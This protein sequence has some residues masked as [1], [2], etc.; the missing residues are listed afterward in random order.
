MDHIDVDNG[1][2]RRGIKSE[3]FS[4]SGNVPVSTGHRRTNIKVERWVKMS[5]GN[6]YAMRQCW[7]VIVDWGRRVAIYAD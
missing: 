4:H 1:Y 2:E 6:V 7:H 3:R 5:D